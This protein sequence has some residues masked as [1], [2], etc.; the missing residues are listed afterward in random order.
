MRIVI[1]G[2][3]GIAQKAYFPLIKVMPSVEVVG[4]HSRTQKNVDNALARWRF[5]FGT[6]DLNALLEL[7]PDAAVVISATAS[8]YDICRMMLENGVDVYAEKSLTTE[9]KLSHDLHRIADENERIL[10]VGFNR[11]YALLCEQA[12]EILGG[13]KVELAIVQKHRTNASY[14]SLYRQFLDDSIHQIDL[15]RYFCGDAEALTTR[16]TMP[17]GMVGSVVSTLSLPDGGQGLLMISG[18]AGAWQESVTLHGEGVT[19]HVDMFR[20]MRVKYDDHEVEYG[21]DRAGKWVSAMKERGF[22]GE[23]AH[24]FECVKTRETA[25]TNAKE[26]AKTQELMEALI[27]VSENAGEE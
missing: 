13:R 27:D 10:A 26:A 25:R 20:S 3:G 17:G 9:S 19:I 23:M 1:I 24:F 5:P 11:R 16:Y 14:P 7:K 18:H 8:H 2:T 6:T 12:K 22:Y 15:M 21:T 4:I